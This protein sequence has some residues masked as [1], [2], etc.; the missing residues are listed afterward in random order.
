LL[1][2]YRVLDTDLTSLI[3]KHGKLSK[4]QIGKTWYI[5][6]LKVEEPTVEVYKNESLKSF[7]TAGFTKS[8]KISPEQMWDPPALPKFRHLWPAYASRKTFL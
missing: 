8:D 6:R 3:P 7:N 2:E 5:F 4:N 1:R